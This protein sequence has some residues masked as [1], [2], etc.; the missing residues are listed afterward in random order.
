MLLAIPP[1]DPD[2]PKSRRLLQSLG[3]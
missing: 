1:T 2:Y 3:Q